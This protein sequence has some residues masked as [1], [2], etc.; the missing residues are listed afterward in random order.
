MAL[1]FERWD[2]IKARHHKKESIKVIKNKKIFLL[3]NLLILFIIMGCR[4][5]IES[6]SNNT[7]PINHGAAIEEQKDFSEG[8]K[9]NKTK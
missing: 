7:K 2:Q 9:N 3:V 8:P 6:E 5:K 4:G 1:Y